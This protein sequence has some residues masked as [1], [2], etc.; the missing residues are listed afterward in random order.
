MGSDAEIDRLEPGSRTEEPPG[1]GGREEEQVEQVV[2]G[3]GGLAL[4]GGHGGGQGGRGW[5]EPP[6][7]A[8]GGKQEDR[9]ARPLVPRVV[10]ELGGAQRQVDHVEAEREIAD[11]QR[12]GDPVQARWPCAVNSV[13]LVEL[14]ASLLQ[15]L[16]QLPEALFQ[17]LAPAFGH[18]L[19]GRREE[20]E[21]GLE[22]LAEHPI[23]PR[24]EPDER[25]T[26]VLS[27][28]FMRSTS[29]R[30]SSRSTTPVRVPLVIRVRLPEFLE[31]HARRVPQA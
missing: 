22:D 20:G 27:G 2:R 16:A 25:R 17:F 24:R 14:I 21:V 19:E 23:A 13:A 11:D 9:H 12:G 1:E 26:P 5:R 18:R 10:L 3:V 8:R 29:P 6:Q 31:R 15:G 28:Q 30:A 7:Q 4:P